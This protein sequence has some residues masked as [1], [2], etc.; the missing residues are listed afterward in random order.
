MFA[1]S[2]RKFT[3][4]VETYSRA[5]TGGTGVASRAFP[6]RLMVNQLITSLSRSRTS[7]R[8]CLVPWAIAVAVWSAANSSARIS[9][10]TV[11]PWEERPDDWAVSRSTR[12]D[13]LLVPAD[14]N[15]E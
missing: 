7:T 5:I 12:G 9:E 8:A 6:R 13:T 11:G 3:L 2:E 14:W 10:E 4:R 15:G 1:S